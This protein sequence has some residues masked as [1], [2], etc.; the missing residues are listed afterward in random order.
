MDE[1]MP[2]RPDYYLAQVNIARMKA[3]LTDPVMADFAARL[4][5]INA[6]A[7]SSPGFVWRLTPDEENEQQL[8]AL[9]QD[10]LLFNLS[11]WTSVEALRAFVYGDSHKA[12][13]LA[14][15]RWFDKL[16]SP[17]LAL[18][19]VPSNHTPGIDEAM[20][21][22]DRLEMV[23]AGPNAFT[24]AEPFPPPERRRLMRDEGDDQ[25]NEDSEDSA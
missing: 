7:E 8:V 15:D 19:W 22:L 4:D 18:W 9:E 17:Q 11:M 6:L 12:L 24:F 14:R 21:R 13:L 3:P 1:A 25:E 5:E 10:G 20:L 16:E 2:G 23:G